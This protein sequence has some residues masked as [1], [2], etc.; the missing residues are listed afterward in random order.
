[1]VHTDPPGAS[2]TDPLDLAS[3]QEPVDRIL[4][5]SQNIH[6]LC[7]CQH[8]WDLFL[9]TLFKIFMVD[10][11]LHAE[12]AVGNIY[13]VAE[14]TEISDESIYGVSLEDGYE[15]EL[16]PNGSKLDA[17]IYCSDRLIDYISFVPGGF[18]DEVDGP[19][20]MTQPFDLFVG[21][22]FC[23]ESLAGL[24]IGYKDETK[25]TARGSLLTLEEEYH[26]IEMWTDDGETVQGLLMGYGSEPDLMIT[27]TYD[28]HGLEG[29]FYDGYS[30]IREYVYFTPYESSG[31]QNPYYTS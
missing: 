14:L 12:V 27:L 16:I 11:V 4:P 29:E 18:G 2:D 28:G 6:Y 24:Y 1:M 21:D 8:N 26:D 23:D 3:I 10:L 20:S 17:A 19:D 25:Q 5:D 7:R 9:L 22:W 30:G 15:I 13:F 31:F